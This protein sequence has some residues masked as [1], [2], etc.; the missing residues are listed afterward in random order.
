MSQA[1]WPIRWRV[2]AV[3]AP[4]K[5]MLLQV[6]LRARLD[7]SRGGAPHCSHEDIPITDQRSSTSSASVNFTARADGFIQQEL[8]ARWGLTPMRLRSCAPRLAA[9]SGMPEEVG[10][11]KEPAERAYSQMPPSGVRDVAHVL[12]LDGDS[13]GRTPNPM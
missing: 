7:A 13:S 2:T 10:N 11:S 8:G 3:D 9:E 5:Q 12:G 4:D 6:D 1:P